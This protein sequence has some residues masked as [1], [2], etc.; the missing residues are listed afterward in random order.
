LAVLVTLTGIFTGLFSSGGTDA[1]FIPFA[2]LAVWRWDHFGK[3]RGAGVARW[4]GPVALG[5][6]CAIKQTPWFCVP[7]L[8]AGIYLETRRSGRSPIPVVARYLGLVLVVFAAVNLPFALWGFW[9]WWHGTVTPLAQPLIADGQ[10]LVSVALHGL[11]GGADLKLL[12]SASALAYLGVL[13]AFIAWYPSLKRIWLLLLPVAFFFSPRSFTGYLIDLFPV[14]VVALL[15]VE[16][17]AKA[18]RSLTRGRFRVGP[19]AVGVLALATAVTSVLALT[20]TAPLGL[21]VEHTAIGS[22][23]QHLKSVTLMV[24]N[25]TGS[26]VSPHFLVDLGA[27]HPSGF[28]LPADHRPLVVGPYRSVTV[29]LLP[30][31]LAYFPPWASNWVVDAYTANPR[32][33][34]TTNDLWHN[35]IPKLHQP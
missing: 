10:G 22:D 28:W 26:V 21:T 27:A 35:Y 31:S 23:Q 29:T 6:A 30:P 7:F 8:A 33:L 12:T 19:L 2:L 3:G 11:T 14:A 25:R 20:I 16:G 13:G 5:L 17:A 32:A 9:A 18:E 1:A 15:T 34:S 24:S 4:I